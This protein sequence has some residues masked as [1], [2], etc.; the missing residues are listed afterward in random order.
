[1]FARNHRTFG[2]V[3]PD[4]PGIHGA[5]TLGEEDHSFGALMSNMERSTLPHFVVPNDTWNTNLTAFTL[6]FHEK[7]GKDID[8]PKTTWMPGGRFRP[9]QFSW[10]A[11]EDKAAAPAHMLLLLLLPVAMIFARAQIPWRAV[12]PLLICFIV[13]FVLF[14]FLLKWQNWHVRLIIPLPALIAPVF[15]LCYGA[16]RMRFVSPL[17][18]LLLFV[19]LV[20]SLNCLQRPMFGLKNIFQADPL[21]TRCYYHFDV[22]PAEFRA[23]A[24][25]LEEVHPK[26]VGFFTEKDAAMSPDYPMQRLLLDTLSQKPVFMSFNSTLEI[27]GKP[28]AD[29][30]VVLVVRSNAKRIQ[31]T[32][33][34]TWYV[35]GRKFGRY[36]LFWKENSN[37]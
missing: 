37:Q 26:L 28:E 25:R 19:T 16:Q 7:L 13:G 33:T 29:P 10:Q 3:A 35:M 34:G 23:V 12:M 32:A 27:P 6:A 24:T 9:Y 22:W 2:S 15:G 11:D 17:T 14:S 18:A 20:P 5:S 1:H 4:S 36:T 30:D 21:A 31:H 8:D